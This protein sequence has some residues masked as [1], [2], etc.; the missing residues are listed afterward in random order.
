MEHRSIR[1]AGQEVAYT[2]KRSAR[3]RTIGLAVG[4][5]GLSVT[6]PSYSSER[7]ARRVL[8][9]REDWVLRALE[10]WSA[11]A[12]RPAL[13]GV[14]GEAI[15]YMGEV[16]ELRVLNHAKARTRIEQNNDALVLKV[17]ENLEGELKAATVRRAVERW[18][19]AEAPTR[20]LG[21]SQREGSK[22][23][24]RSD[25]R[26]RSPAAPPP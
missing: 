7:E 1:L 12:N 23:A 18:R 10:K 17:D 6:L 16:L 20:R 24:R 22:P 15:G 25:P 9:E 19:R 21:E 4:R 13:Q 3:R 5:D 2:L 14:S 26:P 8:S 11:R